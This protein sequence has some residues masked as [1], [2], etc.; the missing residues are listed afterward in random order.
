[1][2]KQKLPKVGVGAVIL[3]EANKVLL[4]LRKKAPEAGCWSLPGGKV[5]Y[6]ETIENAIM[7]EIKEEL[8]VEIEITQLVC[9]TNHIIQ[10]EDVHYV[11][12]TFTARITNGEV[13]NREPHALEDVQWFS[14][15]EIPEN[16]TMTTEYALKQLK[17]LEF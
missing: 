15:N 8:G 1:M 9:V 12:P 13:Q 17:L 7:R 3:D 11:A 4:V 5:D 6:M 10:S 16:I 2:E 14:I